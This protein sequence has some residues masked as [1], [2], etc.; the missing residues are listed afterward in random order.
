MATASASST[1]RPPA[2]ARA[3]TGSGLAGD[4]RFQ[5]FGALV[6][7]S[8]VHHELQFIL[9]QQHSGS[10]ATYM[11]RWAA[12]KPTIGWSSD[13]GIALHLADLL[14]GALLLVL[15]YRRVLLMLVGPSFAVINLVSPER[16][17]SHNSLMVAALAVVLIFGL[18]EMLEGAARRT[19]PRMER[20]D[21]LG[22]TLTGL[23]LLCMLTYAFAVFHKLNASFFSLETSTAP[24]FALLFLE[25]AGVSRETALAFFGYP[26]IYATLATEAMIPI[27]LLRRGTRLLGCFIGVTFHLAM[28]AHGILD[29][30]VLIVGFY[31]LFM[32]L[33]EARALLD[34]LLTRP[35]PVRVAITL[36]LAIGGGVIIA[37]SPYLRNLYENPTEL[38]FI[39][40]W[41]HSTVLHL[42]FFLFA[43]VTS[44]LGAM[45]LDRRRGTISAPA[46]TDVPSVA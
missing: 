43:Y 33:E 14:L 23:R 44:A 24:P 41:V 35:S 2:P 1:N 4:L 30:P 22:W 9:E 36:G 18:A 32:G 38:E 21:W 19:R 25:T 11:E 37:R 16:I 10:F 39:A 15:P 46:A 12:V 8:I 27:L 40:N 3:R 45:L 17:A 6:G 31:P 34:R 13:V 42:T 20:T 5:I 7:L 29:F 28:M 26:T